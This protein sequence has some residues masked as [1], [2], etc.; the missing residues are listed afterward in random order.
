[1]MA[2]PDG[3]MRVLAEAVARLELVAPPSRTSLNP[4]TTEMGRVAG[5][6]RWGWT[7]S[8]ASETGSDLSMR[9]RRV[10][11]RMEVC[12]W[13]RTRS[14]RMGSRQ[15]ASFGGGLQLCIRHFRLLTWG[16]VSK[17]RRSRGRSMLNPCLRRIYTDERLERL[18]STYVVCRVMST[19]MLTRAREDLYELR[20]AGDGC[21]RSARNQVARFP[22]RR[23]SIFGVV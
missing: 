20:D 8:R 5:V 6:G 4:R 7:S 13:Y 11:V 17:S 12:C 22:P 10:P 14:R 2:L 16:C 1:M 18:N 23:R 19:S 21:L 15:G 3:R 9:A